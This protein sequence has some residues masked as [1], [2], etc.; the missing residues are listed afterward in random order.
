MKFQLTFRAFSLARLSLTKHILIAQMCVDGT[1][2]R[3]DTEILL[4]YI[5]NISINYQNV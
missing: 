2:E 1:R 4:T 3:R 5:F